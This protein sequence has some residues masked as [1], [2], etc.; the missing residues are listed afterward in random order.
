MNRDAADEIVQKAGILSVL[1][2]PEIHAD[3]PEYSLANDVTWALEDVDELS[4]DDRAVLVDIISRVV[5]D[6]TGNREALTEF[7]YGL[8]PDDTE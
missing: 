1:Y 2:Y 4:D 7:V 5:I 3:D 6:P 8:V